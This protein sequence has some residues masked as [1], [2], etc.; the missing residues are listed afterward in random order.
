MNN[1]DFSNAQVLL[2]LCFVALGPLSSFHLGWLIISLVS[3]VKSQYYGPTVKIKTYRPR[4]QLG[5]KEG[6]DCKVL[7]SPPAKRTKTNR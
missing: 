2:H 7:A 5:G 1:Y 6:L 4:V 3:F